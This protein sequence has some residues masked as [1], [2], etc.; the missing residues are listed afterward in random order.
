MNY[1]KGEWEAYTGHDGQFSDAPLILVPR[2][3]HKA[4]KV[5]ARLVDG[6][7][8]EVLANAHL[9]AASPD[10]YRVLKGLFREDSELGGLVLV[11]DWPDSLPLA[12]QALA[13][14]EGES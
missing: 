1:T 4:D 14:A 9:I 7:W 12:R 11:D 13:K 6:R 8:D 2:E 3:S 10:M 5:V